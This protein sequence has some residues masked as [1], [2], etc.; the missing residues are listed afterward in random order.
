MATAVTQPSVNLRAHS[1]YHL[2][3]AAELIVK[4]V[5]ESARPID[6]IC[7]PQI[8]T[9]AS[10]LAF[11]MDERC[12]TILSQH[13]CR[14]VATPTA[15]RAIALATRQ[16]QFGR[17]ALVLIP[18]AELDRCVH[19]LHEVGGWDDPGAA[20][21]LLLED[22]PFEAP[23]ACPRRAAVRLGMPCIETPSLARL[24]RLIGD[25]VQLS[26]WSRMPMALVVHQDILHSIDTV[27]AGPNRGADVADLALA[28]AARPRRIRGREGD[29][30]A[31]IAR[32]LELNH[33]QSLPNP[34]D[35]AKYGF[36]TVGP[37]DAALT[38]LTQ[39]FG[40]HH[41]VA[42]LRL[43][44]LHPLDEHAVGRFLERCDNV[45]VLEPRPG[46]VEPRIL[47]VAESMRHAGRTPAMVWARAIPKAE[48]VAPWSVGITL[49][50]SRLVRRV[51]HLFDEIRPGTDFAAHLLPPDI[52]RSDAP[53]RPRGLDPTR[54]T[55]N[56]LDGLLDEVERMLRDEPLEE[57]QPATVLVRDHLP[58]RSETVRLVDVEIWSRAQFL[59]NGI[60]AISVAT[61]SERPMLMLII[62]AVGAGKQD[63]E[64]IARAAAPEESADR[65]RTATGNLN[66]LPALR[67]QIE[68]G[69]RADGVFVMI[70]RDGPPAVYDLQQIEHDLRDVDRLGYLRSQRMVWPSNEACLLRPVEDDPFNER[71]MQRTIPIASGYTVAHLPD[72]IGRAWR[73]RFRVL[74]TQVEVT[75]SRPPSTMPKGELSR[76]PLPRPMHGHLPQW[77]IHIA[78]F[79]GHGNGLAS[80]VLARAGR[81]MG[82]RVG[83][84]HEPAIIGPGVHAWAEL[85][86]HSATDP[87][88]YAAVGRTPYGEAN[89]LIG[90]H[91]DEAARA[92]EPS[93]DLRV[94]S[95]QRTS[96]VINE[97]SFVGVSGTD[98]PQLS[99]DQ[100]KSGLSQ[101]IAS[102][103]LYCADFS[104]IAR[105]VLQT[106]RLTDMV[107]L[108]FAF[109]KGLIPVTLQ[110][111]DDSISEMQ[112]AGYGRLAEAFALGRR[113][114]HREPRGE[115]A[116]RQQ[117]ST[118]L[119]VRRLA[120][121]LKSLPWRGRQRADWYRTLVDRTLEAMPGLTES[122][123]GRESQID[124]ARAT[125]RC[126]L[127]GGVRC[128]EQYTTLMLR[129]YEK[130]RGDT[131]RSITRDAVLPLADVMLMRDPLYVATMSLSAEE[132]RRTR[133]RL[134]V[135]LARE[136]LLERRFLTRLEVMAFR[137]RLRIDLRT[138]AWLIRL[139]AFARNFVPQRWRGTRR[140]REVRSA[141]LAFVHEIIA[142]SD[143]DYDQDAQTMRVLCQ[144]ALTDDLHSVATHTLYSLLQRAREESDA[145]QADAACS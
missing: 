135:K 83:G 64:R 18:N 90:L 66:D 89:V 145:T 25:G 58:T 105:Q 75:R 70:V 26:E 4:G 42:M 74:T 129:L 51:A 86:Y 87:S 10:T 92:V 134:N 39:L 29:D 40:L 140:K 113:T 85:L 109:Q 97:G 71:M 15:E 116:R 76:L 122:D 141:V 72:R 131:G 21:C 108:G 69:V 45:I 37:C 118:R 91:A 11:S 104:E 106:D 88:G 17:T 60:A 35:R 27:E 8:G 3:S 77:R 128:A 130:D 100:L 103:Q 138:S 119:E 101:V 112:I 127:W 13:D 36:I 32:R 52:G 96:A 30:L 133:R 48:Q 67:G 84:L 81:R 54:V 121:M 124:L 1:G 22:A 78:G 102:N 5:L 65:I 56:V 107:M 20:M 43:E 137:K 47:M 143:R 82:Y 132:K 14:V 57:D 120:R 126:F 19:S 33:L 93:L 144:L 31:R 2:Y 79:R 136:D 28:R 117:P 7:G 63:L 111:I 55:R 68:N 50:P 99:H 110:A 16:V 59:A 125:Y 73:L 53:S 38:Y 34:G 49:H 44:V 95:P 98:A 61:H 139:I 94:A 46:S 9:I 41:R 24:K 142:A 123:A 80:E 62:D 115:P 23:A 6:L 114:A 12:R